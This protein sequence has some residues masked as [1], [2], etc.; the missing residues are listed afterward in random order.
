MK[1]DRRWL[2]QPAS[3]RSRKLLLWHAAH[4][5]FHTCTLAH[6]HNCCSHFCSCK[7]AHFDICTL[8]MHSSTLEPLTHCTSTV[9]QCASSASISADDRTVHNLLLLRIP[10]SKACGHSKKFG[11]YWGDRCFQNTGIF[12][13]KPQCGPPFIQLA[14]GPLHL[15]H[16]FFLS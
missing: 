8:L 4:A 15:A 11:T 3:S 7:L 16:V 6:L 13:G 9:A 14:C 5:L 2:I 10:R 12:I 1:H